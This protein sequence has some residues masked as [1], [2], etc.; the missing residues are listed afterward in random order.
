V[1]GD[2]RERRDDASATPDPAAAAGGN[3]PDAP[4]D[5]ESLNRW[6][7]QGGPVVLDPSASM[8][9]PLSG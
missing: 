1:S 5:R 4:E 8:P 7:D 2:D 9:T 3:R 6:D